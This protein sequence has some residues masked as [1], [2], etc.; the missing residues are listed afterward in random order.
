MRAKCNVPPGM[1]KN[2]PRLNYFSMEES[3][4]ATDGGICPAARAR[5]SVV[6]INLVIHDAL[7]RAPI[8]QSSRLAFGVLVLRRDARIKKNELSGGLKFHQAAF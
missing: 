8:R 4:V 1:L 5:D 2:E 6:G 3:G 7:F